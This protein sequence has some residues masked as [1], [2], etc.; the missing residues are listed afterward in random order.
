MIRT[1][2]FD[3]DDTLFDHAAT[4][5]RALRAVC[6]GH[7]TLGRLSPRY[8]H[9]R[10]RRIS[11]EV[12]PLVLQG[13]LTLQ[14]SRAERFHRLLL[15]HEHDH[16]A[17]AEVIALH[18]RDHYQDV[19]GPVPGA[20]RLLRALH[21]RVTV[22]IV[23]NNLTAEQEDKLRHCGMAEFIDFMVTSEAAGVTKPDPA[24]F[25]QALDR[26][27]CRPEEAVM[28]GDSWEAD[29]RGAL[30]AGIGAI[31]FNRTRRQPPEPADLLGDVRCL[32]AVQ[33]LLHGRLS[34]PTG[35]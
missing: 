32:S 14:E 33:R 12:Y 20:Q 24:I 35:E 5:Q 3:L 2:L 11:D 28:V 29:I 19:R 26:A 18:F 15:L 16:R 6:S 9:G 4:T 17:E 23:T 7:P 27:G 31:W 34:Q 25:R 22:G 8:L 30:A 21:G 1:V 13:R 10:F